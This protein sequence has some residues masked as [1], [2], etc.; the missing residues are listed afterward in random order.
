[1]SSIRTALTFDEL[2]IGL[3][4]ILNRWHRRTDILFAAG[5]GGSTLT[6]CRI[7]RQYI[8]KPCVELEPIAHL[9]KV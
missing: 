3:F 5:A 7:Y 4:F 8:E 1:M 9:M 2:V 6:P